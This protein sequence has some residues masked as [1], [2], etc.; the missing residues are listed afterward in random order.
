[1]TRKRSVRGVLFALALFGGA[2]TTAPVWPLARFVIAAPVS[3]VLK[4]D[5]AL[6]G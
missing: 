1:M 5:V 2:A 4:E 6:L 3:A